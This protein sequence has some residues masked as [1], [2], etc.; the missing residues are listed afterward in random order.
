MSPQAAHE[1][2]LLEHS[3]LLLCDKKHAGQD[4]DEASEQNG[5]LPSAYCEIVVN[6]DLCYRTRVKQYTTFPF[7]E[8]GTELFVRDYTKTSLRVV[9]RDARLREHDPILGIVDLPLQKT[10]AHASQ[11]TRTYSLQG[12]VA[13]GKVNWSTSRSA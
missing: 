2:A 4:T 13:C 12:G 9:V 11:A 3:V 10:L 7:Y 1:R 6:D 5:N 8:A